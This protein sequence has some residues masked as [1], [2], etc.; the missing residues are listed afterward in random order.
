M[1]KMINSCTGVNLT[2]PSTYNRTF[3]SFPTVCLECE[4]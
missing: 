4:S 1:S 3:L 2:N